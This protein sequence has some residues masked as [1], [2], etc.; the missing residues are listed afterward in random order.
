MQGVSIPPE[1]AGQKQ[2]GR[3][4]KGISGNPQG[5]PKGVRNK[6]TVAAQALLEGESEAL[7][8]RAVELA[9]TGDVV[10]LRLCL[11]R[12]LPPA[13]ERALPGG[14]VVLPPLKAEN[15]AAASAAIVRAVAAG[16]LTP[17]EGQALA[18][19]LGQHAKNLELVELENRI[20]RLEA[21]KGEKQ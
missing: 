10:A 19:L 16:R 3:F 8:R 4:P 9:L 21:R 13:R 5:R 15:L 14:A 12:L 11:D 1:T 2:A 20:A 17:G 7:T 6:A 18:A